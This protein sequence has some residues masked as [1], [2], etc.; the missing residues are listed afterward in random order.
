M[1]THTVNIQIKDS[2]FSTISKGIFDRPKKGR[3]RDT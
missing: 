1:K 3:S 2:D